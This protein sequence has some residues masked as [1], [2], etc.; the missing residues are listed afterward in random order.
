MKN[1]VENSLMIMMLAYSA[2]KI[3]ANGPPLY[4]T[5]NPETSSDSPSG[6]SNGVRFVSARV[7]VNH[8]ENSGSN[9][10]IGHGCVF[11]RISTML[12]DTRITSADSRI[13]A[14][15][16]SYEMVCATLRT[17][18]KRAY[19]EFEDHPAPRVVYTLMEEIQRNRRTPRGRKQVG[20]GEGNRDQRASASIR[21]K[22][23][24]AKKGV[25]LA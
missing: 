20:Q 18:P 6:K 21:L 2:I 25:M 5:L 13:K 7:V 12:N 15:L 19:F 14:I 17:A 9:N 3:S 24:A 11:S 22:A 10:S 23:G 1:K 8:I 4:S 16:T